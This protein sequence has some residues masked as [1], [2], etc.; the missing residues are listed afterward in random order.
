MVKAKKRD[1]RV[2][3]TIK[4]FMNDDA[5]A[6]L[7]PIISRLAA[8]DCPS[9]FILAL[10][11]LIHDDARVTVDEFIQEWNI[12]IGDDIPGEDASSSIPEEMRRSIFQ[13]IS[14]LELVLKMNA[15]HIL[16]RLMI[17][18]ETIDGSLLQ[19]TNFVLID[20][21]KMQGRTVNYD[22]MEPLTTNILQDLIEPYTALVEEYFAS[23]EE[24][25]EDE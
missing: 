8:R 24:K 22:A 17:D 21:F 6:H 10:L 5:F 11:S 15:L 25:S 20:F 4:Q 13:W 7:F 23:M 12:E 14:R 2:A 19:C 9:L 16:S 3:Q 18:P 1:D